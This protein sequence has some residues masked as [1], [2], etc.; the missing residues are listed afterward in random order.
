[1]KHLVDARARVIEACDGIDASPT[2]RSWINPDDVRVLLGAFT[3]EDVAMLRQLKLDHSAWQ[4]GG[5]AQ[6]THK[7][8]DLAARIEALLPP[9]PK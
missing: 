9:E 4:Y 3:R 1:M 7:V 6:P 8:L 2:E 5:P